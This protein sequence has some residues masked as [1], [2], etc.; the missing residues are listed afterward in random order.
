M[1]MSYPVDESSISTYASIIRALEMRCSKM[2]TGFYFYSQWHAASS[3]RSYAKPN[4]KTGW[5]VHPTMFLKGEV[6]FVYS[7]NDYLFFFFGLTAIILKAKASA[8]VFGRKKVGEIKYQMSKRLRTQSMKLS[9]RA[10]YHWEKLTL[11]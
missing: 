3:C 6:E 10:G 4:V 8:W 2:H 1:A 9:I 11:R 5:R 7:L